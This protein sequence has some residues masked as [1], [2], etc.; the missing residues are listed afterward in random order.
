MKR[1][2]EPRV[3]FISDVHSNLE[4]LEAVLDEVGKLKVY[5]CGDIVGYGASPNEV[6]R[7]LRELGPPASSGTTTWRRSSGD[8]G[9]FNPR[10]AMAAMWT[11]QHLDDESRAFLGSLPMEVRDRDRGEEGLHGPRV[12]RRPPCGSTSAPP[13]TR[14]SST[15]T[16]RRSA[17]T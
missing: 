11:S 13:P 15:T 14:T 3:A 8:V 16:C 1:S 9:D 5:C 7:V 6:V 10:A 2:D 4:A 17:P 12:A